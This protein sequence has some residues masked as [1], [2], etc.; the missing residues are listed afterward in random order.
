MLIDPS[1]APDKPETD[2]MKVI[3]RALR[4]EF[5][6]L[7]ALVAAVPAGDT[8]RAA[9]IG[10]HL[11]LMLDM[12]HDHHEA[13][14]ELL[15][16]LL[17][18]RVPLAQDLL[19][20]MDGQHQDIAEAISA[21]RGD[22]PQWRAT[23]G[24]PTRDRMVEHLYGLGKS[25]TGHLDLEEEETLPLIH[26]HLTVPEWVAPQKHALKHGP[27]S[28]TGK[29]T[30]VGVVLEDATPG[31]RAWFLSEMP[32][33]ARLLWRLGGSRRYPSYVRAVRAVRAA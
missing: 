29:L 5:G 28:L 3:H 22:V 23:A 20:A 18:A 19:D 24:A 14:D 26:E 11:A 16:P 31:E 1:A 17:R 27:K 8:H 2:Q 10:D 7:P 12:L 32:S 13:E 21:V 30:L 15:W 33:A 9:L 4:R 6:L 25:L